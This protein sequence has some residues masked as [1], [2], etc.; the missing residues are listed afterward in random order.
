MAHTNENRIQIGDSV[1]RT[2][3]VGKPRGSLCFRLSFEFGTGPK[4]ECPR[5]YRKGSCGSNSNLA[6]RFHSVLASDMANQVDRS[7]GPF[8]MVLMWL[9]GW[10]GTAFGLQGG[11]RMLLGGVLAAGLIRASGVEDWKGLALLAAAQL[12][13]LTGTVME[14]IKR[15]RW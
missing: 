14:G 1:V 3:W 8:E 9:C 7:A 15:G 11:V 4:I 5:S 12:A 10:H 6:I 2:H 13:L